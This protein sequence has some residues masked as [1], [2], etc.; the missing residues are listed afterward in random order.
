[1]KQED[2]Y[3]YEESMLDLNKV[4]DLIMDALRNH[5]AL[6]IGRYGHGEIAYLGWSEFPE[7][8]RGYDP[9]G[10][11]AGA[12]VSN[13]IIRKSLVDALKTTDIAGFHVSGSTAW[14]DKSAAD[15]TKKLLGRIGFK[16]SRVCSAY[17]THEMIKSA[18]FWQCMKNQRIALVGRRAAEAVPCFFDKGIQITYSTGLEGYGEMDKVY[19]E[20]SG[21]GDWD[22]A[23]LA[24]GIPA[25]ILAPRLARKSNKVAIDFGHALDKLI[26]GSQYDYLELLEKWKQETGKKLLISVVMSAYNKDKHLV[27]AINS[28]L[29][30]TYAN[31]EMIIVNNGS[32]DS[33]REILNGIQDKRVKIMHLDNK[34]SE[35]NALNLGIKESK[36]TWIA[37]QD[38]D[39][40]SLP[41]RI[42]EQ[43]K[44]VMNH[45]S[46]V[47]VGTFIQ[48][49]PGNAG[50]HV[51]VLN[52]FANKRNSYVSAAK[53]REDSYRYC[54]LTHSAMMYS[55]IAFLEAGGYKS[56]YKIAYDCDLWLRLLE[57]GDIENIKKVLLKHRL[58]SNAISNKNPEATLIEAQI[59][60]SRAVFRLLNKGRKQ[61][62]KVIV[63]GHPEALS[64]YHK[65]IA[66]AS[67][68]VI[69]KYLRESDE[70]ALASAFK[71]IKQGITDALIVLD[72]RRNSRIMDEL[73][74]H[75]LKQNKNV[76]RL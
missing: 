76:F 64:N 16:P 65:N 20:L 51:D 66:P 46:L 59:A 55:K 4:L 62:P 63:V 41:S 2:Y 39:D 42:E 49:I 35:A 3:D 67:G 57:L 23:L 32:T 40:I 44:Y 33:T 38:A 1:M 50:L 18:K 73:K 30:Q 14:E 53:I 17:I 72:G 7:W 25:T 10:Y 70:K 26:D 58:D 71:K 29:T 60:S 8:K 43:V 48:C 47:G 13:S 15:L 19:D 24:A 27:E 68:L 36:G 56:E 75:S 37:I 22:I 12:T 28:I 31:I 11:Y 45:P 9:H 34:I 54:P 61:T 21:R 52:K 74:K 6:S 5:K 69:E